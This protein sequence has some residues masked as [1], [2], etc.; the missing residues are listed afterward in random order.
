MS[1][2]EL[3]LKRTKQLSKLETMGKSLEGSVDKNLI[4]ILSKADPTCTASELDTQ[5]ILT[6]AQN[7]HENTVT[8]KALSVTIQRLQEEVSGYKR[9]KDP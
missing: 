8:L 5:T 3:R 4:I 6:A 1:L 2:K 9:K 7:M